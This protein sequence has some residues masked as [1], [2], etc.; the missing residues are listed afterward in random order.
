[1][2]AS[3][4][5][6]RKALEGASS[7][8]KYILA[9]V[10]VGDDLQTQF[11]I[12]GFNNLKVFSQLAE[13][14]KDMRE[15]LKKDFALDAA[16]DLESRVKVATVIAAFEAVCEQVSKENEIKAEAKSN[17][18][19]RAVN[20]LDHQAMRAAYEKIYAK[21]TGPE[22]PS[23]HYLGLKLE[24]VDEN[25]PRVESLRDVTSKDDG[26]DDYLAA[27]VNDKGMVQFRRGV[28]PSQMPK[29][30]EEL[31]AKHKLIGNAWTMCRFKHTNREWLKGMAPHVMRDF[32]DWILGK[33]VAGLRGHGPS[34][35]S[36]GPSWDRVCTFEYEARK[37]AYDRVRDGEASLVDAIK[38]VEK[39]AMLKEMHLVTP[40]TLGD[41]ERRGA[42]DQGF[43]KRPGNWEDDRGSW[44]RPGPKG[45]GKGKGKGAK[46]GGKGSGKLHANTP[47]G[48]QICFKYNNK[49]EG[50]SGGCQRIHVCR[51]CFKKHPLFKHDDA[52]ADGGADHT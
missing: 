34:N 10:G 16:A 13:D 20:T 47:D 51:K 27:N 36:I 3:P 29:N 24:Q 4:E 6:R 22:I 15:V 38:D 12:A 50:C 48:K 39:D 35:A 11:Y 7:D 40:L 2:A 18:L 21:L 28:K 31:R 17:R 37:K 19:P 14:A 45:G 46:G 43:G 33:H 1:M 30:P 44:K 52:N 8:L 42:G 5:E 32:S 25:E 49:D 41:H 23:R 9:D 26:E